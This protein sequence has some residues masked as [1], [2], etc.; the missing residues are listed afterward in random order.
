MTETQ[1]AP[2][3]TDRTDV[4][5]GLVFEDQRSGDLRKVVYA[6]DRVVLARD[7]A[8]HSTLIPRGTF[9]AD[10][11][12]RYRR[13][14]DADPAVDGGPFDRLLARL[15]EYEDREGRKAVHKADALREALGVVE[16]DDDPDDSPEVPFEEIAGIGPAT[17]AK[18][19][20]R[21]FVTEDDVR[22]ASDEALLGVAGVGPANLAAVR[23]FLD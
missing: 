4:D 7:E 13:R 16:S 8:G 11:D 23:E 1:F 18:L 6:D 10:L 20:S 5:I 14:R 22:A 3:E 9:V 2:P 19:R 21:G 12:Q 15:A 17:A